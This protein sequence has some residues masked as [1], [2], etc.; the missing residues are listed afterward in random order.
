VPKR[1]SPE[2][3]AKASTLSPTPPDVL[4]SHDSPVSLRVDSS[5]GM[6]VGVDLDLGHRTLSQDIAM[7]MSV[8]VGGTEER[9]PTGGLTYRD[10]EEWTL[11][12]ISPTFQAVHR[13]VCFEYR[14]AAAFEGLDCEFHYRLFPTSPYVE[15]AVTFS[16]DSAIVVRN[17]DLAFSVPGSS[18]DMLNVPGNMIRRNLPVGDLGDRPFGVSPIGGLRGSSGIIAVTSEAH[19]STIWP[20]NPTEIPD[21][22]LRRG[23]EGLD[24]GVSMNFAAD[25]NPDNH[26]ELLLVTL[27]VSPGGFEDLRARWPEWAS[28]YHLTSPGE[29][30][31]WMHGSGIYEAQIGTSHFWR[32]NSY[33]RY[34]EVRDLTQDLERIQA[35]GFSVIQLMPRQPYPSYNVHDYDDITI[36][37]GDE[38]E[39]RQLVSH[40]HERG[41]RVILDVLLHG[42]LDNESIDAAVEG[43]KSGP[44]YDKLDEPVL[45]TFGSDVSDSGNYLIAWSRHILDFAEHWRAGSPPRT[46]LQD[47]HPEWFATDSEGN[48]SGVYT[49]AFDARSP[50]WQRYF[51]DA[52][53]ELIRRTDADGFRFDAPTYNFF[54]NWAPW[55][56][57]RAFMSP[58]GCVPLFVDIR[59]DIKALKPDALMYTEPSGHL[60]RRS[61]DVNYNYDE[62]WLVS[63]LLNTGSPSKRGVTNA[64]HFME[65]ME[66]R[67]S[68][69]PVGS[70]TAHHIDSH[71][72]FWWPEWGK[73]WRREQYSLEAVRA[74]TAAFLAIDGPYMMFTGGEEGIEDVLTGLLEFRRRHR[75][76]WAEPVKFDTQSNASGNVLIA[77]RTGHASETLCLV[78]L[79]DVSNEAV[80]VDLDG[81][82][83]AFQEGLTGSVLEPYGFVFA[84]K[85]MSL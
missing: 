18:S 65:W 76:L 10:T 26:V 28:R 73:K 80:P 20:N 42:V 74:L 47:S 12:E 83:L 35:L 60:L 72:T 39:L 8:T 32:G 63:A 78:N 34:A 6:V 43:V 67:D 19:T 55:A 27:D 79:S 61:M 66:D 45:D 29:P 52:M 25:V 1:K 62:Q 31:S 14:R 82:N 41:M 85:T 64:R 56:R 53:V 50:G 38:D 68:F 75:D 59:N 69:L 23:P 57:H 36:S 3:L 2:L 13:G 40:C 22:V 54:A 70:H 46:P 71:D 24:M 81:W 49:K 48:V 21:I 58:L 7:N 37:Y 84:E 17:V 16:A 9:D 11:T 33:S 30:P 5:T 4:H 77:Y 15:V 44:L 51:R